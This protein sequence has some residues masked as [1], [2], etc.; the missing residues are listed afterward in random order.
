MEIIKR[1][2]LSLSITIMILMLFN[3][4]IPIAT[5]FKY[6]SNK[7][8]AYAE[9][10]TFPRNQSEYENFLNS[11]GKPTSSELGHPVN[12]DTFHSK[13]IIAYGDPHCRPGEYPINGE[14][15]YIG[16]TEDGSD[17]PNSD[18][19][20]DEGGGV[21]DNP[22]DWIWVVQDGNFDSWS[23]VNNSPMIY[24]H[25]LNAQLEGNS[26]EDYNFN[27]SDAMVSKGLS[28]DEMKERVKLISA[29]TFTSKGTVW[30][31]FH[32]GDNSL[33]YA[34]FYVPKLQGTVDITNT[35]STPMDEFTMTG[36]RD[37][38]DIPIT[39]RTNLSFSNGASSA[40]IE[41]V[42]A[43][44]DR[45]DNSDKYSGGN[46]ET[47]AYSEYQTTITLKR[48]DYPEGTHTISLESFGFY[49]TYGGGADFAEAT[50]EITL[51]V[52]P[53]VGAVDIYTD[54]VITPNP[55]ELYEGESS[56]IDLV[57]DA[58]ASQSAT[59]EP[60]AFRY[61]VDTDPSYSNAG[62][63]VNP[64]TDEGDTSPEIWETTLENVDAGQTIYG[65]VK[66]YDFG[67][68]DFAMYETSLTIG[69]IPTQVI[70]DLQID[71]PAK[72][73]WTPKQWD[74]DEKISVRIELDAR[75]SYATLG[76]DR[77][78]FT[79]NGDNIGSSSY[80]RITEYIDIRPSDRNAFGKIPVWA[81][82]EVED[83]NG[84]TAS[85]MVSTFISCGISN[86]PPDVDFTVRSQGDF[87]DKYKYYATE[88]IDLINNTWDK[89][90]DEIFGTW[91]IENSN[92]DLI[93]YSQNDLDAG[94]TD[95]DYTTTYF[96]EA[97][98]NYNGGVITFLQSGYYDIT[99][100]VWDDR[101]NSD[102]KTKTI[103]VNDSPQ[104][105]VADFKMYEFGFP[106]ES[107]SVT[108][109]STDPNNDIKQ[110]IWTKPAEASG[111]LSG[112][113]GSL[114]FANE[115]TYDV[116]LKVIDNTKLED[117]ITKQ[118]QIIPPLAVARI[119][120]EGTLKENR[121]VTIHSRDSLSPRVDP[122]QTERNIWE[123]TPLDGQDPN[124]I[125]IDPD[126]SN[127]EEKNIV[128]KEAGRYK[129]YLKVHNNFSDA[130]PDHPNYDAT[131]TEEI[132]T[133]EEDLDPV[134]DFSVGG[135]NPNFF[136]N[137]VST[138]VA[139]N[140]LS[141]SIDADLI[142]KY[143]YTVY[144]DIDEDGD[145]SDESIYG[146]YNVGD[147]SIVVNFQQGVSGMFKVDLEVTEE[148]GQPTIE[149]FVSQSD[150][151]NSI[152]S[153]TFSVNWR[154]D[155]KFDIPD[156]AYTDDILNVTTIL[157]DEE[158]D[159]LN[160]DWSIKMAS[161]SNPSI[162]VNDN[163]NSRTDNILD[164][165]GGTIRFKDSGYYE[166]IATVTDEIGQ[167][168]SF[169]DFI[170]V[171]PLPTAVI[172]DSMAYRGTPFTTKENRKYQLD[173]NS[174]FANDYYGAELHPIDH[175]KDYWEII[176][177]DGQNANEVIKVANGAGS[178]ASDIVSTTK[179]QKSN[180]AFQEDLLFKLEGRYKVRYQI[181]NTYGKKSPFAEQIINVVRDTNPIINFETV[182]T[183]YRDPDDSNRAEM[184]A[185]NITSSSD[186]DDIMTSHRIRYRYDS[187]NDGSFDD[188]SWSSPITIDFTN[189]RATVKVNKVG[190]YQFE[191]FVKDE[192]GQET[193]SQFVTTADR[194]ESVMYKEVEV[195]NM[196]PNVDFTVTPSN[197]VDVVFTVGEIDKS[198][199]QELSTKINTYIKAYLEA[200]N[201]DFIDTNIE[202]I[203][204]SS[205]NLQDAFTW[206][207]NTY[208]SGKLSLQNNGSDVS[209]IGY[210]KEAPL[211]E[212]YSSNVTDPEIRQQELNFSLAFN[213]GVKH[214]TRAGGILVNT[215]VEGG[216][217]KG[218]AIDIDMNGKG[219]IYQVDYAMNTSRSQSLSGTVLASNLNI[220]SSG[221]FK[222]ITTRDKLKL[223]KN[224]SE[225]TTVD[226]P[227]HYG[228]GIGF[229]A[230]HSSHNCRRRTDLL[231]TN[232]SMETT[233]GKSLDEVL[234][235]P[236][237][238]DDATKF[239]VNL[240][241]VELEE[242]N[243]SS[244]KYP[245]VLSRMLNESLYFAELGTDVNK[246]QAENF[247]S[248]N[249]G[250]GTFIYNNNPSM[251]KALQDLGEWILQTVRNQARPTTQYVLLGEEINYT[252]FYTD[253]END[254]QMNIENWRYNHDHNYFENSLGQVNYHNIW[255]NERKTVFDKVG[256]FATEYKTKDNPVGSDN[257]FDNYRKPS[258]MMN[259]ALN[260]FVHRKPLAQFS[261]KVTKVSNYINVLEDFEDINYKINLSGNWA[262]SSTRAK[263]GSYS[264][265]NYNIGNG[266]SS[267]FY[268]TVNVPSGTGTLA[269]DYMVSSERGYDYF[270]VY[271]DG[272]RVIHK[273]G[274]V[275]WTHYNQTL[276]SGSH[277][278]EF[279]YSKDGSVSNG[280][281]S[282]YIDNLIVTSLDMSGFT[283]S[284]VDNS[285]D[286]DHQSLST[287]YYKLDSNYNIVHA[288]SSTGRW[289][290]KGG[291]V[292][293][294]W[295]WKKVG[296]TT[297]HNGQLTNGSTT[298]DYLVRLR[299]R[300][301]DGE[302]FLGT[303]SDEQVVLITNN[304]L[305]PTA[306][307]SVT[308][309]TL[310]IEQDL[311]LTD[312]SYDP[313][314]DTIVQWEWKLYKDSTL[315]GTYTSSNPQSSVNSAINSHGIG[316][317]KL[318]LQV[319]DSTGAWGDPK[320]TSD[321]FTQS[322]K[323]IPVNHTPSANFNPTPNPARIYQT[324]NWNANYSDPDS[325]NTGF[326][327]N[328]TLER[329][330]ATNL[331]GING[332]PDNIYAYTGSTPFS[333]SFESN[334][335]PYGAYRITFSVTDKPPVPPY[336]PTDTTTVYDTKDIYVL[337]RITLSSS[338][339]GD[340]T[341]GKTITLKATTNE[342]V[343]S[344]R[345][346]FL[347]QTRWLT[348]VSTSGNVKY[349]ELD[350]DIPTNN[351]QLGNQTASF[352]AYC[353][354]GGVGSSYYINSNTTIYVK[355][356]LSIVGSY[357]GDPI[358][359]ETI[360]LKAET[361][362]YANNVS[363]NFLGQTI[364]LNHVSTVGQ[365][366]Y[367]EK[368]F[369]IPDTV[370]SSGNYPATFTATDGYGQTAT[371]TIS[372]YVV[373]LKLTNYRIT[374]IVNHDTYSYPLTR[375]NLPVDYRTGYYV[376][377]RIDAKGN[378]VSVK[379]KVYNGTT[380][381]KEVTLTQVGTSG[382]DTIW[383]GKY[384]ADAHLATGT[385]IYMDLTAYKGS[386]TYNYNLKEGW[387]GRVL[388]VN[389]TALEDGRVNRTN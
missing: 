176:P 315:I 225:I 211:D 326:D 288:N 112:S 328:W 359:G 374:D 155:I 301:M 339:E 377:F 265:R 381:D 57:L 15:R 86:T 323:V 282:A 237:W 110:R 132:I 370:S 257:R 334:G 235:E 291:I 273:S 287:G 220:G 218:Y 121:K 48:S 53:E 242:L 206:Y 342:H 346:T 20:S 247:I 223:Y 264:F 263:D 5:D 170:R 383:E 207:T 238:R 91:T 314:G 281:D 389:G 330:E 309:T 324:I 92:G 186:D 230:D 205:G 101:G 352:R 95:Q 22:V 124:S 362:T 376:T 241:D 111:S 158:I 191:Y 139:I 93:F 369:V 7:S 299:V 208:Q 19:P 183:T 23:K 150:R 325:D 146:T 103:Y 46:V 122:I 13:N 59:G 244:P 312:S 372:I 160:V 175:T 388:R 135:A 290:D 216:R 4:I 14:Y 262:R 379:A 137:P 344:L 375:V 307:F 109:T 278:V 332:S 185:H 187:D 366:K 70:A 84:K 268:L 113:G 231:I 270:S 294:E 60:L 221:N 32:R 336:Q 245:V 67:L 106:N 361:T 239:V 289:V 214:A 47:G 58:S 153:K 193:L 31:R 215:H 279:R 54:L 212:V 8:F 300:D 285:Y 89:E 338:Y 174:S 345:V 192:F 88:P 304:P 78:R 343:T 3:L 228:W 382:T 284:Y 79:L 43:F 51:T 337:P 248:D 99:L 275:G 321:I 81:E 184:I 197:K 165:N 246:S 90:E 87:Y 98:V 365:T 114:T 179:Y 210:Y 62:E 148:F 21:G 305:P 149:K 167:S 26:A 28:E 123:I 96:S 240:S 171:Y 94:T 16:Y 27:L 82:V 296:E 286:L 39:V 119:T 151:R 367:W 198:K 384:Y 120:V 69:E 222:V 255:L 358:T 118:I 229:Y 195:D 156:W 181:T 169:S 116:T 341:N 318:T 66:V 49:V 232:L 11:I 371:D 357:D 350:F 224:G 115:G 349:W 154:P 85:A 226:L 9:Y 256:K 316:D 274:S 127:N 320:A 217:M 190:K 36:S 351:L 203:E 136:D 83:N 102:S 259:G 161:E 29:P 386:T 37:S 45:V 182:E 65:K 138:T 145:F 327:L 142:D 178:L 353:N 177:L 311:Q 140:D 331:S 253:Y 295:Q 213:V 34:T 348:L 2:R 354:Y 42:G 227:Q 38:I 252:L 271:V 173:G 168:Y 126:T 310:P 335:L 24:N 347:G 108:D 378:P 199:T 302:N 243:P 73:E 50:K 74:N 333:G 52:E 180:N 189:K 355:P 293:R 202:M 10:P 56:D 1:L 163:I 254:P 297:W 234:K 329:Y 77:Y 188:E 322:F 6:I 196:P 360:T 162:M 368:D 157:K 18:F 35:I 250:K 272:T 40:Y 164:N 131:D 209:I 201:A 356:I 258:N 117:T 17:Y 385:F 233:K 266:G 68:N 306:Q 363:V 194:R 44:L 280:D 97:N 364:T 133:I 72:V 144:R 159:T 236:T 55:S 130:N 269:F 204:T 143:K 63:G 41:H 303:W 277:N 64:E 283:V 12:L 373:A 200:N 166:L 134:S 25:I 172:K 380:L 61:W 129:I 75:G 107:I 267:S 249:D 128:F 105:P 276:S 71:A 317:Y 298:T 125:K 308:P 30:I 260:I 261:A 387:N 147:T 76:V 251:D 313:N 104:P 219:T 152:S 292:D 33:R 319:R 340:A 100:E 141:Y 80:G